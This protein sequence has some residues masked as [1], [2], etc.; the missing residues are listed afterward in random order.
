MAKA[1]RV[2]GGIWAVLMGEDAREVEKD[3]AREEEMENGSMGLLARL[4]MCGERITNKDWSKED[5]VGMGLKNMDSYGYAQ[6]M[7]SDEYI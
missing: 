4:D 1:G 2:A 3:M 5:G 7:Q 6:L